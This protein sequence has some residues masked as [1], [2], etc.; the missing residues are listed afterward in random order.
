MTTREVLIG[1]SLAFQLAL[2]DI[3]REVLTEIVKAAVDPFGTL[4]EPHKLA[5]K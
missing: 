1:I 3:L 2:E 4:E 5:A